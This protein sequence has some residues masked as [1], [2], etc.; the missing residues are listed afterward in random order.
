MIVEHT[1]VVTGTPE[2]IL[3]SSAALL[4]QVG[5]RVQPEESK[6]S[7]T[8]TR[9]KKKLRKAR[10]LDQNP[11][12]IRIDYDRGRVS[13]GVAVADKGRP[14]NVYKELALGLASVLESL[15]CGADTQ[16]GATERAMALWKSVVR[17]A[18]RLRIRQWILLITVLAIPVVIFLFVILSL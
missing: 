15:H 8:A 16:E 5:Y 3:D 11:Q 4:E 6:V 1:Y 9:G 2:S 13:I 12:H 17:R 10:H 14:D 7:I 18:T